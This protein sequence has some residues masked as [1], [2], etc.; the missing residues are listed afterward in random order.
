MVQSLNQSLEHSISPK[1]LRWRIEAW[2]T[3]KSF[4]EVVMLNSLIYRVEEVFLIHRETGRIAPTRFGAKKCFGRCRYG[5]GDA[6]CD[7][8]LCSRFV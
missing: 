2:Q 8:G 6:D 4:A 7:S 1:G 5:F 3:G